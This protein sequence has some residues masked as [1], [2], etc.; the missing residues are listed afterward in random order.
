MTGIDPTLKSS[1]PAPRHAAVGGIVDV[2]LSM[3]F[4]RGKSGENTHNYFGIHRHKIHFIDKE[5]LVSRQGLH[6]VTPFLFNENPHKLLV[7]G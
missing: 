1:P 2:V 7:G 4:F 5:C 6:D 3:Y